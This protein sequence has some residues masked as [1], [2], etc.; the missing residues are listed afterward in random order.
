[1][2]LTFR[3]VNRAFT[4]LVRWVD[5]TDRNLGG[6][7]LPLLRQPSRN[8]DVLR[9]AQ[10]VIINYQRPRER[11][12]FNPARDANP[13]FHLYESLWMLA[14][15][16]DLAPLHYYVSTFDAFSDDGE[17]LNGAYGYRWRHNQV[18]D[19]VDEGGF[20]WD[21]M[22][23]IDQLALLI[24][25]LKSNPT[26]RRAVL[27]MWNVEDDLLKVDT[28]KDV[29]CNLSATFE[30]REEMG[31]D[32]TQLGGVTVFDTRITRYLDI[33]VFNRSNDMILGALGANVVHFSMLQ[34]YMANCL[35][36][37]VGV[38]NQ[39]TTNLHI[40]A[41]NWK[42][43]KWLEGSKL[44]DYYEAGEPQTDE[45]F[46]PSH[47]YRW[48]PLTHVPLVR[49]QETF[50]REVQEFIEENKSGDVLDKPEWDEPFLN[51]VAQPMM[52][53]FHF[54]KWREYDNAL[55]AID[56]MPLVDWKIAGRQWIERRRAAWEKKNG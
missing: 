47:A 34:E 10:P 50:D 7:P 53:A 26:S 41:S 42:P 22:N 5:E 25:H 56:R 17:T 19:Y 32:V 39:I 16:N 38:Y 14:G 45:P 24:D 21:S 6:E 46:V 20:N 23:G 3:N 28:S 33:N 30:I 48:K 13:F 36:V 49:N 2:Y 11:V 31:G 27:A 51:E 44:P 35:R 8:G 55:A 37:E 29:C 54:H 15:R 12:L 52:T 18:N 1:M 9:I 4:A 43:E 40:Y